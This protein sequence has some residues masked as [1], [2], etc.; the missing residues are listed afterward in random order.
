MSCA[1]MV[2]GVSASSAIFSIFLIV[3]G[4]LQRADPQM[5]PQFWLLCGRMTAHGLALGMLIT[6]TRDTSSGWC[7]KRARIGLF[8][9]RSP[10][11][12]QA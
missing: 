1:A 10:A 11:Y 6:I 8:L 9:L 2:E 3:L 7:D 5:R 12:L 4:S